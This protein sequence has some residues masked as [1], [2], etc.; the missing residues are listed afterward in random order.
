VST[1]P[2]SNA[3][4]VADPPSDVPG[5]AE[6]LARRERTRQARAELAERRRAGLK[7]RHAAKLRRA[8]ARSAAGAD[9]PTTTTTKENNVSDVETIHSR[10]GQWIYKKTG[11]LACG[12][13]AVHRETGDLVAEGY[14]D[15]LRE[16]AKSGELMTGYRRNLEIASY[17]TAKTSADVSV[18]DVARALAGGSTGD[19]DVDR[20]I[21]QTAERF[22]S[23]ARDRARQLIDEAL[24]SGR[25]IRTSDGRIVER[26]RLGIDHHTTEETA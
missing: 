5:H 24:A 8:R 18:A 9:R 13:T 19:P 26:P 3:Q 21:R 16:M 25:L 1:D 23:A 17:L 14:L 12:W 11:P 7:A 20:D 6:Y 4:H 22:T 2:R 15:G 10:D